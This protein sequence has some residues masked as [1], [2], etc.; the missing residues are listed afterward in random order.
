M[1]RKKRG[2]FHGPCTI[3]GTPKPT[4]SDAC[5]LTLDL[6]TSLGSRRKLIA[7]VL[8]SAVPMPVTRTSGPASLKSWVWAW[9]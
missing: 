9:P 2:W 7:L 4:G 6:I 1:S 8:R 5:A 3:T